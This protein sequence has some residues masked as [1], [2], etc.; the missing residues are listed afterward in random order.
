MTA[1]STGELEQEQQRQQPRQGPPARDRDDDE[2]DERGSHDVGGDQ[3]VAVGEAVGDRAEQAATEQRGDEADGQGGGGCQGRARPGQ[4]E[5]GDGE[6]RQVVTPGR[7]GVGDEDGDERAHA[8]KLCVRR[9]DRVRSRLGPLGVHRADVTV[10]GR[11]VEVRHDGCP[12]ATR[13]PAVVLDQGRT[14]ARLDGRRSARCRRR[15]AGRWAARRPGG[16]ATAPPALRSR[17]AS[18]PGGGEHLGVVGVEQP[19]LRAPRRSAVQRARSCRSA[20]TSCACRSCSSCTVHS[21]SD[22]P[23]RPSLRCGARV[24]AAGQPLGLDPGLDPADL[25]RRRRR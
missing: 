2:P 20:G 7:E 10:L 13:Q 5:R 16:R 19:G 24:G 22:S 17:E 15:R 3:D 8:E 6:P 1:G 23:P 9:H 21:T 12:G 4:D 18:V 25:A 14:G 11:L